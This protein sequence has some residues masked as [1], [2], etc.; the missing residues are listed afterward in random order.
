MSTS[1]RDTPELAQL[2][3]LL[4]A[5]RV[6]LGVHIR[7]MN[8]PGSPVYRMYENVWPAATILVTSFLGTWA[9]HF[10][11]GAAILGVG[12]WWWIA[13]WLP[14]IK[15]GVF[16]RTSALVLHDAK[17]FDYWWVAGVLSLYAAMPDGSERAAAKRDDWREFVRIVSA[18]TEQEAPAA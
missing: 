4:A 2:R 1:A 3:A 6:K 16:E 14:K 7:R 11:L 17:Q 13:K 8:S 15:D 9:V 12:C 18:E 10:Y 5:Q